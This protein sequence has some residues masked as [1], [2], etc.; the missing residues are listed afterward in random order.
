MGNFSDAKKL[1]EEVLDTRNRVFGGEHPHT[2]RAMESLAFTYH[3]Q[4]NYIKAE[5]FKIQVQNARNRLLVVEHSP[6]Y[7]H[8]GQDVVDVE[9]AHA[10]AKPEGQ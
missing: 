7:E 4:E 3:N 1:Q 6:S 8:E 2:I 9:S 10:V 5:N